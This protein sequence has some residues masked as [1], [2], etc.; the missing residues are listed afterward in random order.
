MV[1]KPKTLEELL[2]SENAVREAIGRGELPVPFFCK[3]N[4]CEPLI[5]TSKGNNI[6]EA[7]KNISEEQIPICIHGKMHSAPSTQPH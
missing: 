7:R 6:V 2:N 4:I 5:V 1:E 3:Y